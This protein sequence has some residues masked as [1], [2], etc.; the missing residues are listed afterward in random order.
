MTRPRSSS[1]PRESFSEDARESL[2][3]LHRDDQTINLVLVALTDGVELEIWAD[4][5]LRRRLRFLRD[6]EA[7]KYSERLSAR[8]LR[9]SYSRILT[10]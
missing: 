5:L 4:G 2:T 6:T 3:L 1:P 10:Q 8:L 9:R 7:R